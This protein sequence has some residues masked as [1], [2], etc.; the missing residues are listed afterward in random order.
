MAE[1]K[2]KGKIRIYKSLLICVPAV[3]LIVLVF[4]ARVQGSDFTETPAP[5]I[6]NGT[7]L[8][9]T[10]SNDSSTNQETMSLSDGTGSKAA[11]SGESSEESIEQKEMPS[12]KISFINGDPLPKKTAIN[13]KYGKKIKG[14]PKPEKQG[15]KFKG[16]YTA[17]SGGEKIKAGEA[18]T[19]TH[20]IKLYARWEKLNKAVDQSTRSLPVL[21]YHQFIDTEKG[22]KA[23]ADLSADYMPVSVFKEQMEFLAGDKYYTPS[24]DEIYDYLKGKIELPKKSVV[25][26]IDDGAASFYDHA[27]PILD[28]YKLRATGFII[29]K[30]LKKDS[31]QK[32]N[33]RYVSLQSHSHNMHGG[34]KN[35]LVTNQPYNDVLKDLNK[36]VEILGN[37]DAFCYPFGYKNDSAVKALKEVGFKMAFTT[38]YGS[39]Y[40]GMDPYSL[41]RIKINAGMTISE[42]AHQIKIA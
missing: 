42:F 14:M 37:S 22:E 17:R 16:W 38:T 26:T 5:G 20:D 29:T 31:I 7:G 32:F 33:S 9:E 1:E 35:K 2:E 23:K 41:P 12:Y 40:P 34:N 24:W 39:L 18:S 4:I 21:T 28:K 19:F 13:I 8:Y 6:E 30:H 15:Y 27:V 3:F 10:G 36:S 11:G 25:I